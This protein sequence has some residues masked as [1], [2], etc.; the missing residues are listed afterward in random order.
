MDIVGTREPVPAVVVVD[1]GNGGPPPLKHEFSLPPPPPYMHAR[2]AL[3][4]PPPYSHA[5]AADKE[6]G[7]GGQM[8]RNM[9]AYAQAV[10][11]GAGSIKDCSSGGSDG[12]SGDGNDGGGT[13]TKGDAAPALHAGKGRGGDGGS[14]IVLAAGIVER[15][16]AESVLTA[17][18]STA[19]ISARARDEPAQA[20]RRGIEAGVISVSDKLKPPAFLDEVTAPSSADRRGASGGLGLGHAAAQA[21]QELAGSCSIPGVT[22]AATAVSILVKLVTDNRDNKKN[23][24]ASL[25]RC[26][27]TVMMLRRA[28]QVFGKVI[29]FC[30]MSRMW[31]FLQSMCAWCDTIVLLRVA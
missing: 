28:E 22:E 17:R 14:G 30:A 25:G 2:A 3:P 10:Y 11:S 5:R 13:N 1:G 26:R 16:P 24:D 31:A 21:A 18:T 23:V 8:S 27:S 19:D 7:G 29:R 20:Y 6:G 12:G 9:A 15:G 4:P